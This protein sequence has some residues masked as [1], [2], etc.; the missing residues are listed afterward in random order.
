MPTKTTGAE[1]QRFYGDPE[2]WPPD[3]GATW[4]E[5]ELITVNGVPLSYEDSIK[6]IAGDAVVTV[7]GGVVYSKEFDGKEP[8]FESYFRRWRKKQT[9]AVIIVECDVANA[10]TVKGAIRAAGAKVV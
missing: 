6:D 5:D 9:T 7:S 10:D 1:L 8:S 4:H 2:F 3:D